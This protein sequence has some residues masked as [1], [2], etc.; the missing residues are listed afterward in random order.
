MDTL[1]N[2]AGVARAT[3]AWID[4]RKVRVELEDGREIAF[5]VERFRRLRN[6]ADSQLGEV[7]IEA[8]GRALRWETLD[9][10]LTIDGLL[11]ARWLP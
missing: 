2:D 9:E 3:R 4:G 5:P 11:A 10:D 8:R 1:V 6:A 7:R